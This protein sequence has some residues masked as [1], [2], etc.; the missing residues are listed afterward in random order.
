MSIRGRVCVCVQHPEP[1]LGS[2]NVCPTIPVATIVRLRSAARGP[3]RNMRR[4][5][6]QP[7]TFHRHCDLHS[8]GESCL[9]CLFPRTCNTTF[10]RLASLRANLRPP[11]VGL[12]RLSHTLVVSKKVR[13]F[14]LAYPWRS[15]PSGCNA[16]K[17]GVGIT[18]F[19]ECSA[20]TGR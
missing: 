4:P 6:P 9:P 13:S 5:P 11:A 8:G 17:L 20:Q 15:L 10:L 7:L 12:H 19:F 14:R 2:A 3:R 1:L 16:K 18:L